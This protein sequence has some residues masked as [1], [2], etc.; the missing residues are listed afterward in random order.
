MHW[1]VIPVKLWSALGLVVVMLFNGC[2]SVPITEPESPDS[3][4]PEIVD[5]ATYH[6]VQRGETLYGIAT[7][8]GRNFKDVAGWNGIPPPYAISPGQRLRIDGP[9]SSE[10]ITPPPYQDNAGNAVEPPPLIEP[11]RLPETPTISEPPSGEENYHIVQ[12]GETLYAIATRYGQNFRDLAAWNF[13]EPPYYL[14]IGQRLVLSGSESVRSTPSPTPESP[15]PTPESTQPTDSNP[16]VSPENED[17][18]YHIVQAGDTL[19]R[20]A[21]HY[22]FGV[23]D[24]AAWNGLQSPYN[25]SLGQKLRVSPPNGQDGFVPPPQQQPDNLPSDTPGYHIVI[26]GDTLYSLSRQ[27]GYTV[28]ELA[29]WNNLDPPYHLSL[30]QKLRVAPPTTETL[31]PNLESRKGKFIR[32]GLPHQPSYHIVKTGETLKSIANKYEVPLID[33]ADWNGIGSPYTIFPGLK[34]TI[35]PP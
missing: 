3:E 16:P 29:Q 20:L 17:N 9:S 5:T 6:T 31:M 15:S 26:P 14:T 18:N 35:V 12:K 2:S 24:L 7:R 25:L 23:T 33:L 4:S 32:V 21:R 11:D 22:G 8:Y 34:L 10:L 30:G 13:I 27:Y 1:S 28:T 19:Y